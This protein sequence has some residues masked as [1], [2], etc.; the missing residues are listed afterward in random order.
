M[1]GIVSRIVETMNWTGRESSCS[2]AW[3][4]YTNRGQKRSSV[5]VF[6]FPSDSSSP[7]A[8][9]KLS[10]D[11]ASIS[12]EFNALQRLSDRLP[13]HVPQPY[14]H[15][16]THGLAYLAMEA[17]AAKA[18]TPVAFAGLVPDALRE[19]ITFHG[20]L[21]EGPMSLA[22]LESEVLDPLVEFERTWGPHHRDLNLLCESLRRRLGTLMTVELPQLPQHGDFCV[23]NLLIRPDGRIVVVDWEEFGAVRLPAYDLLTL[24]ASVEPRGDPPA[25][26]DLLRTTLE[27]YGREMHID[28]GWLAA[29]LP[30]GLM[31]LALFRHAESHAEPILHVLSLLRALAIPGGDGARRGPAWY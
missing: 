3:L 2:T 28:R 16:E 18:S 23:D 1:Q 5:L 26:L 9:V 31:R 7:R 6:V 11:A 25:Y 15:G 27:V 8:I 4:V 30:I 29:L 12:R 14:L 24:F 22:T 19:L 17:V 20:Q 13:D 10:R 21:A